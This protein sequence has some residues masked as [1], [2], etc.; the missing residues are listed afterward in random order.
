MHTKIVCTIGPA[1]RD[2]RILKKMLL[3]GMSVARL[4]FS[5]GDHQTHAENIAALR[6]ISSALRKPLAIM[7]D[8]AGPKIRTGAVDG[9]KV[10]LIAGAEFVL[11]TEEI[12]GTSRKVSV[13]F[14]DLP[15]D[16]AAGDTILLA[17][18]LIELNIKEVSG[19]NIICLVKSGGDLLSR[20]GVNFPGKSVNLPAIT[21]KDRSDLQ[22]ILGQE[23]DWVAMSFVRRVDDITEL[24]SLIGR[25]ERAIP[26]VAKIEKH[27]AVANLEEII[28]VADGIMLARGDLGVEMPTETVPVVQKKVIGKAQKAGKPVIIATQMLESMIRNPRPTR[29]EASDVAN[30]IF[31]GA[32]AVMLSGETAIGSYPVESVATMAKIGEQ[33]ESILD[34]ENLLTSRSHWAAGTTSDA[35]SYAT[36]QLSLMLGAKAIITS[37]QSG[38]TARQ[39][40]RYRPRAPIIA[41]SPR[42]EIVRQLMLSWG[43][44][45]IVIE[46]PLNIDQMLGLAVSAA[47]REKMVKNGDQVIIT[48]GVLV[49]VPG[50]TNLIKVQIVG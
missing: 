12:I 37:T 50:T 49:N 3:A 19:N 34:W 45:P 31:D 46:A 42:P 20:Q 27:E 36:C 14:T 4:N 43:V 39:V 38:Q 9:D 32:D 25:S 35:I 15:K 21:D 22:F 44:K 18:G 10:S 8:L 11:T 29:A 2:R 7:G 30:A 48:A 5:H 26:V 47:K 40:S 13:N 33:A 41:V 23:I 28:D 6:E 1:S 16:V 24:K 17:D